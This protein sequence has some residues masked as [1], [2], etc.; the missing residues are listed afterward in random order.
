MILNC[1][2]DHELKQKGVKY[3]MLKEIR[4]MTANVIRDDKKTKR[5][6]EEIKDIPYF[7]E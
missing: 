3:I 1:K 6:K 7:R 2:Y 4:D 5:K